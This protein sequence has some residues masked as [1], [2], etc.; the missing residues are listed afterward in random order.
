MENQYISLSG[1]FTIRPYRVVLTWSLGCTSMVVDTT[2]SPCLVVV[3]SALDILRLDGVP[4]V[5]EAVMLAHVH[6]SLLMVAGVT[7]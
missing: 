3:L 2:W 5:V 1:A 6:P 7:A 4:S